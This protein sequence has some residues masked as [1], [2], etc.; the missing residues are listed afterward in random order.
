MRCVFVAVSFR[1]VCAH[2]YKS[3]T[4]EVGDVSL[5]PE[6]HH[7]TTTVNYFCFKFLPPR[8]RIFRRHFRRLCL[9]IFAR[10]FRRVLSAYIVVSRWFSRAG[11]LITNDTPVSASTIASKLPTGLASSS[12]ANP[13]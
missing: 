5:E 7:T 2:T 4:T 9:F 8:L 1:V 13:Q 6:L 11:S 3:V 12:G 10:R